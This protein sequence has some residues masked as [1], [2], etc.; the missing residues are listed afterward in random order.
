LKLPRGNESWSEQ[1]T[2]LRRAMATEQSTLG[3]FLS[4]VE[5]ALYDDEFLPTGTS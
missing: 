4:G 5:K 3:R 1:F 2:K